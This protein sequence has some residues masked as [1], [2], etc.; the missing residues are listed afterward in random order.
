MK[1]RLT[2]LKGALGLA[3]QGVPCFPCYNDKSPVCPQGFKNA[4]DDPKVLQR[5]WAHFPGEL[6]GVPTGQR[7]V[8]LDVDLQ[9]V[10]AQAWYDHY[11]S[12]GLPLT[13]THVTR[14][15]GRHLLFRPHL[16]FRNSNS[17]IERG[18]DT[19]GLGNYIVWWPAARLEVI[20]RDVLAP[21]PQ[22]L[23][24]ALKAKAPDPFAA[25]A[26]SVCGTPRRKNAQPNPTR[27]D[28]I[29]ATVSAAREGERN[30][31][32]HWAAH[33]IFEMQASGEADDGALAALVAAAVS[34]GLSARE[35]KRIID[36]ARRN[37]A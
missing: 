8:V 3:A 5:L 19:K 1:K 10:E 15:G 25:Y 30:R 12:L 29:L 35:V 34:A 9:L 27:L 4:T 37:A 20:H 26:A 14:S 36:S 33:R 22:F 2:A 11:K 7:F 16:G 28:A 31:V 24:D 21:V 6:F 13:R 23:L 17:Q 18:V 32:T